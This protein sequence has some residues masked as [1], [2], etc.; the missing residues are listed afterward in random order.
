MFLLY[1]S[2]RSNTTLRTTSLIQRRSE[3]DS[4]GGDVSLS[5]QLDMA[6]AFRWLWETERAAGAAKAFSSTSLK[7]VRSRPPRSPRRGMPS[8]HHQVFALPCSRTITPHSR[9]TPTPGSFHSPP[10]SSRWHLRL[11]QRKKV[12]LRDVAL[13]GGP[14]KLWEPPVP[15]EQASAAGWILSY[16][17]GPPDRPKVRCVKL[18]GA[19]AARPLAHLGEELAYGVRWV[20]ARDACLSRGAVRLTFIGQVE[21]DVAAHQCPAALRGDGSRSENGPG[22]EGAAGEQS[23]PLNSASLHCARVLYPSKMRGPR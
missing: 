17:P 9:S 21:V 8:P 10:Q 4:A 3:A 18:T 16:S 14:W 13:S 23:P 15:E 2:Q 19:R 12:D 11:S 7:P 20:A 5:P 1:F 6:D 22:S